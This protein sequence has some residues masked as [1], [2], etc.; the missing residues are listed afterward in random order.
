[1]SDAGF[2]IDYLDMPSIRDALVE[3]GAVALPLLRD[4]YRQRLLAEARLYRYRPARKEVGRDHHLVRQRMDVEP[5]LRSNSIFHELAQSFSTLLQNSID[6]C[7]PFE[8]PVELND[9]MLQRYTVGE[10]G[11]TPHRDRTAYRYIVALIVL[12]GRGRFCV[13]DDRD[14]TNVVEIPN[15]PGDVILMRAPGF[16][17]AQGNELPRPFHFVHSISEPR[18]I[19]GLRDDLDKRVG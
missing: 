17:D 11:I 7:N 3:P 4:E 15:G 14:A 8:S 2:C 19:F 13:A 5:N 12:C 10:I 9:L 18:Y 6:D 1:M 16:L